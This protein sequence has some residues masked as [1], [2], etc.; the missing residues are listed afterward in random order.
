MTDPD[1]DPPFVICPECEG[2]RWL[3][4][5][6]DCPMCRTRGCIPNPDLSDWTQQQLAYQISNGHIRT[7]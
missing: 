4:D 5:D 6:S 1:A 7:S 3:E 2:R